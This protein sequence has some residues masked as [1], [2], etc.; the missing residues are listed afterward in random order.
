MRLSAAFCIISRPRTVQMC[1]SFIPTT[2]DVPRGET[3]LCGEDGGW[4]WWKIQKWR[5][6]NFH[7]SFPNLASDFSASTW[8]WL[9]SQSL[10]RVLQDREIFQTFTYAALFFFWVISCRCIVL[11]SQAVFL[12]VRRPSADHRTLWFLHID[13]QEGNVQLYG[14]FKKFWRACDEP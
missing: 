14:F 12:E 9:L 6:L 13:L 5:H 7:L 1:W 4:C 3:C 10:S 8:L 2:L 11:P